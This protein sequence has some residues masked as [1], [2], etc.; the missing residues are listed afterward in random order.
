MAEN[1]VKATEMA[2]N[3]KEQYKEELKH[4]AFIINSTDQ[5]VRFN[6]E[7]YDPNNYWITTKWFKGIATQ[8]QYIDVQKGD[9]TKIPG[10][11]NGSS[12]NTSVWIQ[13]HLVEYFD[14]ES[15]DVYNWDGT[16]MAK[17]I[18]DEY[19]ETRSKYS[20]MVLVIIFTILVLVIA[21]GINKMYQ[22]F[23]PCLIQQDS[24]HE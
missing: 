1:I 14:I 16:T 3:I 19:L 4:N 20:P 11:R 13:G 22:R 6:V 5:P 23:L 9:N 15:G 12:Y 18:T 8:A 24:H 10:S 7:V 2:K 17:H 21:I